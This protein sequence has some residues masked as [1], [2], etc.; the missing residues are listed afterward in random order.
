M[1]GIVS[2][3]QT[4]DRIMQDEGAAVR[5]VLPPNPPPVCMPRRHYAWLAQLV[6]PLVLTVLV[7]SD[8]CSVIEQ[9]KLPFDSTR[10][11]W[12]QRSWRPES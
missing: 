4:D 6:C 5:F 11:W 12:T 2:P 1:S 3:R 8:R 9:Q 7:R 10:S